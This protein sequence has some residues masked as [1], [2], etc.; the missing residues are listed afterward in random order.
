M[1]RPRRKSGHSEMTKSSTTRKNR[2]PVIGG[3]KI[4]IVEGTQEIP[5]KGMAT[6]LGAGGVA[7]HRREAPPRCDQTVEDVQLFFQ[8]R[9]NAGQATREFGH[10]REDQ[11]DHESEDQRHAGHEQ[12]R[13]ERARNVQRFE[14]AAP[15]DP[16]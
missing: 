3:N 5:G 16:A 7:D 13:H 14:S 8:R 4:E 10:A 2:K 12:Q 11:Q 15:P 6:A 9:D 1:T